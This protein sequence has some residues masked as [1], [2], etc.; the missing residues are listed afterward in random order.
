VT[1]ELLSL[2]TSLAQYLKILIRIALAGALK[3]VHPW[4]KCATFLT[5]QE[6]N[7][8]VKTAIG[9]FLNKLMELG[10]QGDSMDN[11]R[12]KLIQRAK[13]VEMDVKSDLCMTCRNS[14]EDSCV[15]F[16]IHRWHAKCL[17]CHVCRKPVVS[18]LGGTSYDAVD[19]HVLC[20]AHATPA[21]TRGFENVTQLQ[22]FVFLLR[23]ALKRLYSLLK[24]KG[25]HSALF[26]GASFF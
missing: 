14:V 24:I 15:R 1:Q 25:M 21:S 17:N 4:C 12:F 10:N 22:Q 2:V 13:I 3:L 6:R 23:V 8:S 7:H 20:S 5:H 16:N 9:D 18:D 19:G 11:S 26:F